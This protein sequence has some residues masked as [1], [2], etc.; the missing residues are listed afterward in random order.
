MNGHRNRI[1][2]VILLAAMAWSAL[3][4]N[5]ACQGPRPAASPWA[6]IPRGICIWKNKPFTEQDVA[7]VAKYSLIQTMIPDGIPWRKG[8][9]NIA[10]KIKKHNPRAIVIGYKNIV[11]HYDWHADPAIFKTHPDWFIYDSQGRPAMH[12]NRRPV[13]DLR[14]AAMREWWIGDVH[15]LL[16]TPGFDG[17]LIDAI[18]KVYFYQP[19]IDALSPKEHEDYTNAF[20]RMMRDTRARC[21]GRG[22]LIGNCLRAI[23]EDAGLAILRAYYDGSYLEAF[24]EP[25][26]LPGR[27]VLPRE[28]WVARGI[29]AVQQAGAEGKLIFLTLFPGQFDQ[30]DVADV[31][32]RSAKGEAIDFDELY[33]DREYK[34]ALFLICAGERSYLGY[35][36]SR[37]AADDRRLWDPDY[38]E[39]HK[40]LGPPRGPA[41]RNGYTYTREF[42]HASVYL[43]LRER[44]GRITWREP[45]VTWREPEVTWRK[46]KAVP[47]LPGAS[48]KQCQH[49]DPNR[50]PQSEP[51]AA[52][53]AALHDPNRAP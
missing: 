36:Y 32:S 11:V 51:G 48:Q 1:V 24:E 12:N 9:D 37:N 41:L 42:E 14:N 46:P 17:I 44:E 4:C 27:T 16:G 10:L 22:L 18:T 20:H 6:T 29:D 38:P 28:E 23:H 50:T 53:I 30:N 26:R 8:T 47:T 43:D 25:M 39:F 15:R 5:L 7:V 21:E 35:Q 49:P 33:A 31:K 40:P 19:I 2:R 13:H 34:I 45:E 52:I 3:V